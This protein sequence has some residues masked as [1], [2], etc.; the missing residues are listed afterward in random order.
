MLLMGP[1]PSQ[2][3][4]NLALRPA[5]C[6]HRLRLWILNHIMHKDY[7]I[8]YLLM[9]ARYTL[10]SLIGHTCWRRVIVFHI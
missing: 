1:L 3:Y 8:A 7:T 4:F 5:A 2:A 6:W 9:R 10:I